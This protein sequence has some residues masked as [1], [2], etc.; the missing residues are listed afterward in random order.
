V[1][2]R[3]LAEQDDPNQSWPDE[4]VSA[5]A[6]AAGAAS[7]KA[8]STGPPRGTFDVDVDAR[9]SAESSLPV[10]GA[11]ALPVAP[12]KPDSIA[13]HA[14][15]SVTRVNGTDAVIM[16]AK[17]LLEAPQPRALAGG[18]EAGPSTGSDAM[19]APSRQQ[20]S[21]PGA[22]SSA[23]PPPSSAGQEND[24]GLD[25]SLPA[26]GGPAARPLIGLPSPDPGQPYPTSHLPTVRTHE[27]LLAAMQHSWEAHPS[28][29]PEVKCLIV[30]SDCRQRQGHGPVAHALSASAWCLFGLLTGYML[31]T[32]QWL[33][34][35]SVINGAVTHSCTCTV[36]I[37]C[38][39]AKSTSADAWAM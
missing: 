19:A 36:D 30:R 8:A 6:A 31:H 3:R 15:G 38:L 17:Q 21:D 27:E 16:S 10:G 1:P 2:Q 20:F 32:Q 11:Q 34:D 4:L 28:D 26:G 39:T 13:A 9:S 22:S 25:D 14:A 7:A 35:P 18:A 37:R 5:P 33:R 29:L 23:Q 12:V 24:D